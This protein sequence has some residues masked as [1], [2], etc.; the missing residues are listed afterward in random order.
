MKQGRRFE[1]ANFRPAAY[2]LERAEFAAPKAL[3]AEE[4]GAVAVR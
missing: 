1:K 3:A 2:F 4:L